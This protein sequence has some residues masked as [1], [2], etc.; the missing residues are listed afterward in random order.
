MY[1]KLTTIGREHFKLNSQ[2]YTVE[3]Q[4]LLQCNSMFYQESCKKFESKHLFYKIENNLIVDNGFFYGKEQAL[5]KGGWVKLSDLNPELR[6]STRKYSAREDFK[7]SIMLENLKLTPKEKN[8]FSELK[9]ICQE[10]L[11]DLI[12]NLEPLVLNEISPHKTIAQIPKYF[13]EL[14]LTNSEAKKAML[15]INKSSITN[16][17]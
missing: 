8:Y 11:E 6:E 16:I 1:Q 12:D 9:D 5:I 7:Y 2:L 3:N 10:V 4:G 15:K 14:I 13:R 17:L